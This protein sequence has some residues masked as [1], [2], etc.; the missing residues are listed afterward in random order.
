M[1]AR[2][3]VSSDFVE[4]CVQRGHDP[5]STPPTKYRISV[6]PNGTSECNANIEQFP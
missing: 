5:A 6:E 2:V 4:V 3:E 1:T